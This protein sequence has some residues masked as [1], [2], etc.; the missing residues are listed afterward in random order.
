MKS[1]VVP[2]P[3][4]KW[5]HELF[6][7]PRPRMPEKTYCKVGAFMNLE[8]SR[9]EVGIPPQDFRTMTD[10]TKM[11]MFLAGQVIQ[12]SGILESDVPRERIAVLISQNPGEAAAT[13]QDVIIRG[14][15]NKIVSA[16]KRVVD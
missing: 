9:K 12:E 15:L 3:A 10:S 4:S 16:V 5:D 11:S 14:S 2:I 6:Y 7:H 1:G 13:L 8:V